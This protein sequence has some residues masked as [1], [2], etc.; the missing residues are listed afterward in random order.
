VSEI[1]DVIKYITDNLTIEIDQKTE[2]GPVEVIEVS[3]WI[4]GNCISQASC[5]LPREIK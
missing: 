5:D 1:E 4:G 2:F 3:L